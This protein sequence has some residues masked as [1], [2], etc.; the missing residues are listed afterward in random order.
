MAPSSEPTPTLTEF[1]SEQSPIQT[2]QKKILKIADC[3]ILNNDG[4]C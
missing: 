2:E 1:S 4:K 3:K